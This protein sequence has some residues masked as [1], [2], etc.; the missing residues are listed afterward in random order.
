[1]GP[2]AQQG[3]CGRM[4]WGSLGRA[5]R[6]HV[7][8]VL[9]CVSS[10]SWVPVG[11]VCAI[12]TQP[13]HSCAMAT[14][15]ARCFPETCHWLCPGCSVPLDVRAAP[16]VS[17]TGPSC[18]GGC[19]CTVTPALLLPGDVAHGSAGRK[20]ER[21]LGA[22]A[23]LPGRAGWA[24]LGLCQ[25][26]CPSHGRTGQ[27]DA[28]RARAEKLPL[29]VCPRTL[30]LMIVPALCSG[31]GWGWEQSHCDFDSG[32]GAAPAHGTGP[33]VGLDAVTSP[34]PHPVSCAQD[35]VLWS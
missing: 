28:G 22:P 11:H 21:G 26:P 1:M 20:Q 13:G 4:G 19:C 27:W 33:L 6:E 24:L 2:G 3:P 35:H 9:S 31:R 29:C 10:H 23:S 12:L 30:L 7:P 17:G 14:A 15:G 32:K 18:P 16:V 34:F 8:V 5:Y 25:G